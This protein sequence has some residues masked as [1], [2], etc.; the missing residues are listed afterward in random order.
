MPLKIH[1]QGSVYERSEKV[2]QGQPKNACVGAAP[3]PFAMSK[4]MSS[5][6]RGSTSNLDLCV[7]EC[8]CVCV[9]V[10]V[11][12]C[13]CWCVWVCVRVFVHLHVCEYVCVCLC[14]CVC[15]CVSL[16]VCTCVC[17]CS[18]SLYRESS[19]HKLADDCSIRWAHTHTYTHTGIYAEKLTP[20]HLCSSLDK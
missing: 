20:T 14:V 16:W 15:V 7:C 1:L 17:V 8:V 19:R 18:C 3:L 4:A 6:R 11:L 5:K 10:H 9:R 12:M 2:P 13:I